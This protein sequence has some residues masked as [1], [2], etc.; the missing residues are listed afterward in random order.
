MARSNR[1]SLLNSYE[2]A[3]YGVCATLRTEDG[4]HRTREFMGP[5]KSAVLE[6]VAYCDLHGWKVVSMSTPQ[7]I[8][9]DLQGRDVPTTKRRGRL[10]LPEENLLGW[11]GR[12]DLKA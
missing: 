11:A 6:L 8:Y 10:T 1:G 4:E 12:M 3:N 5:V 9:S 2:R 7:T